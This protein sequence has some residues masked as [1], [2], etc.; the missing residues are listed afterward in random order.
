MQETIW[1]TAIPYT[2]NSNTPLHGT[3]MSKSM[4]HQTTLNPPKKTHPLNNNTLSRLSDWV[5]HLGHGLTT[6]C[7]RPP[8]RNV[9]NGVNFCSKPR[10]CTSVT[11]AVAPVGM[12]EVHVH[13]DYCSLLDARGPFPSCWA[14]PLLDCFQRA[15]SWC[16]TCTLHMYCTYMWICINYVRLV[17]KLSKYCEIIAIQGMLHLSFTFIMEAHYKLHVHVHPCRTL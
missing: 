10:L 2:D 6:F 11:H 17:P 9:R 16:A 15:W 4:G 8:S 12:Q 3:C 13:T 7:P 1:M 14:W 5:R